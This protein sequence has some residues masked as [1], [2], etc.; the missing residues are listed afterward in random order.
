M[1]NLFLK[2]VCLLFGML[3][4]LS[5]CSTMDNPSE[6]QLIVTETFDYQKFYSDYKNE[7][8]SLSRE[9]FA[10]L[11]INLRVL[12]FQDFSIEK[13][14]EWWIDKLNNVLKIN[15]LTKEQ[16]DFITKS[17]EMLKPN[18]YEIDNEEKYIVEEFVEVN[19]YKVGIEDDLMIKIFMALNDLDQNLDLINSAK[20]KNIA[21]SNTEKAL[22]LEGEIILNYY[23]KPEDPISNTPNCQNYSCNFCVNGCITDCKTTPDGCGIFF[24]Y[25]CNVTCF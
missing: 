3:T 10:G 15:S 6:E 21:S 1:K 12:A 5:S 11:N 18:L 25:S 9:E 24:L 16:K 17:K 22:N 2:Q 7:I 14:H 4:I 13:K 23:Y 20:N 19:A 8:Q